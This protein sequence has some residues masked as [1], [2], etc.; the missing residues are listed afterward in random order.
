[1][2]DRETIL[3]EQLKKEVT[4]TFLEDFP[5]LNPD[6]S[7]WKGL[8]II[9]F[10]EH[11]R[12]KVRGNVS[13]KW[14]Y[15]YFKSSFEKLP[16]ID[17]LNLLAQYCGY[18]RGWTEFVEKYNFTL[19]KDFI[20]ISNEQ[21][22]N[23]NSDYTKMLLENDDSR[24]KEQGLDKGVNLRRK[25]KKL[26]KFKNLIYTAVGVISILLL[27]FSVDKYY[28]Y[29]NTF[30]FCFYDADRGSL[31]KSKLEIIIQKN[32]VS[33]EFYTVSNGCFTYR[34]STDTLRM[35]ISS[36]MYKKESFVV[37]LKEIRDKGEENSRNFKLRP[38]D[39]AIMLYYYSTA[40]TNSDENKKSQLIKQ[41]KEELNKLI[42][43][44][45]LI[46]QVYD[47]ELFGVEVL[48]KKKYI[49]FMTIPTTSLK[50]YVLI[51]SQINKNKKI[52]LIKF[53]IQKNDK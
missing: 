24:E 31:I 4:K 45:A 35:T 1:M 18:R 48:D 27:I 41:R 16:R 23:Q 30:K 6:I 52:D 37:G 21:K 49:D 46:Y 10:Q 25:E 53:K 14:F 8:D 51:S 32:G 12:Q 36:P 28:E 29:R 44:D 11:L 33:P 22:N 13:E 42:A 3:F 9:Y 39:Y 20:S 26:F 40:V 7:K 43:D 47:N 15:T 5:T 2:T 50:N 19:E 34:S 38:D 17:M